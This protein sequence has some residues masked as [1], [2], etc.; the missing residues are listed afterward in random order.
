[1]RPALTLLVILTAAS[2]PAGAAVDTAMIEAAERMAREA[3][4][5]AAGDPQAG[6]DQ[7]RRALALTNEFNPT[8]FVEMGRK[9]EVVEDEFQAARQAYGEHR[10]SLY[11]A[12]GSILS[13]QGT[14]L[15]ASRY[16]ARA[17]LLDP[18]PSRGLTLARAQIAIGR[19]KIRENIQRVSGGQRGI[20]LT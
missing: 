17:F 13:Q 15:A 5:L 8:V 14:H 6:L 11:A 18:S 7:A 3:V 19:R 2:R 20:R 9:G 4:V 1:M 10:A 12:V 16:L